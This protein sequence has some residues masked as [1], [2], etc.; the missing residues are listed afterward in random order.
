[1]KTNNEESENIHIFFTQ[2]ENEN[3]NIHKKEVFDM[4]KLLE[5]LNANNKH[6]FA[7]QICKEYNDNFTI[8]ELFLIC[9]YYNIS[10][11]LKLLK[12]NKEKII[13][14]LVEFESCQSN[15]DIVLKRKQL[16]FY[17]NELKNDKMMKKFVIW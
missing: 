16:W 1:M 15:N 3:E 8:K 12:C 4:N 6:S 17:I 7:F 11:E 10:K 13:Q 5:E 2:D 9:D 14:S